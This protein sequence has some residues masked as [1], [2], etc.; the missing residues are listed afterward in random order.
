MAR[1]RFELEPVLRQRKLAEREHQREVAS[2]E[3]ERLTIEGT[4]RRWQGSIR[5]ERADMRTAH[6]ANE[7]R[8][9]LDAVRVQSH[10]TLGMVMR[11]QRAAIELSGVMK[12][13]DAAR[14]QLA[15]AAA[16]R[17]AIERLRERRLEAWRGA[18][19]AAEAAALDE[20][21]VM[22]HGRAEGAW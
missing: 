17:K 14:A 3:R 22:R 5:Q 6:E 2:L 1:F 13:L 10:A 15:E 16:A 20:L 19:K 12:R 8:M 21:A 11:A 4:L 7:G 9:D 18:Q